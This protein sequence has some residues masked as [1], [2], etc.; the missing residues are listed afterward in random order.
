MKILNR[1]V[2]SF[3]R[4]LYIVNEIYLESCDWLLLY[5]SIFS[6]SCFIVNSN[7]CVLKIIAYVCVLNVTTYELTELK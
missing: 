2:L 7:V 4:K 5:F 6:F 3:V 1:C